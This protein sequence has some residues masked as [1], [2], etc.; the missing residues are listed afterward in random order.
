MIRTLRLSRA[1]HNLCDVHRLLPRH[2]DVLFV[3][4]TKTE[5]VAVY[6]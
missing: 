3:R 4:Y 6:K 1:L 5:L 2:C